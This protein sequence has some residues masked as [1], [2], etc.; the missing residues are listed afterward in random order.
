MIRKTLRNENGILTLD[1]IFAS[2]LIFG[3]SAVI[4]SFGMTLSVVEVVQYMSFASA[5]N[6]SLGHL[7]E[8]RQRERGELKFQELSTNPIFS[9][10]LDVGWFEIEPVIISDFNA[11][12]NPNASYES[13]N[14]IGARIPFG[15]PY[16]I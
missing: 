7:N 10:M 9:T 11:E 16:F 1:F 6:Y 4:F 12:Y 5:R 3:L 8:D 15:A 13:N 2:M 14:F